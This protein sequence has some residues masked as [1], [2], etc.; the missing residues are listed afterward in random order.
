MSSIGEGYIGDAN[1][2]I[3]GFPFYAQ[4]ITASES[5]ARRDLKRTNVMSGTQV[6][7]KSSYLPKDYSFTA[8]VQ[9]PIDKPETYDSIFQILQN[10]T[11]KIVCKDMGD[12]FNA[13]VIIK[14][15]HETSVPD[16][17]KLDIQVVEVPE[18][19]S[20]I[21]MDTTSTDTTSS[22]A[23]SKELKELSEKTDT[24]DVLKE[25]KNATI[26]NV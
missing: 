23:T 20:S 26:I 12:P 2:E 10:T 1:V 4:E 18:T 24:T 13:Q 11:P 6:V 8:Y 19:N 22:T 3:G 14:K 17:I 25:Y 15:T 7:T 5:F 16:W 9:V 21:T